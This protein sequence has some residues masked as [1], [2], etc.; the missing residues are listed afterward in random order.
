MKKL[1]EELTEQM[2]DEEIMNKEIKEQLK[3]IGFNI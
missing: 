2:K 3:K 1:T